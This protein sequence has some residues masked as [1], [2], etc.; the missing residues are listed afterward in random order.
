[1]SRDG[2]IGKSSPEPVLREELPSFLTIRE[3]AQILRTSPKAIYTMVERGQLP[4]VHRIRS[5]VLVRRSALLDWLLKSGAP[6]PEG[7]R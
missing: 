7:V 5:R 4:G 6:S 3:V 1:M 2:I